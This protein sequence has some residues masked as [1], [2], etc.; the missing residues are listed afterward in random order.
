MDF[1]NQGIASTEGHAINT[2]DSTPHARDFAANQAGSFSFSKPPLTFRDQAN[3][4]IEKGLRIDNIQLAEKRLSDTNYYRLRGF[5]MTLEDK[6]GRFCEGVSFDDIWNT[7]ELD[8]ALRLWLWKTISPIEVKFRT[9]FAYYSAHYIGPFGYLD[10]SNFKSA[11]SHEASMQRYQRECERARQQKVPYVTH[12]ENRYGSLPV[13]AAVELMSFGTLSRLYGNLS[14]DAGKTGDHR[15]IVD[16]VADAFGMR[17]F[18][19]KNWTHHLTTIRNIAGHHD[20]FYNRTIAI[21]PKLLS[22]DAKYESGK[23]FPTLLVIKN[24][25]ELSWPDE[26]P[27][28]GGELTNMIDLYSQVDLRPMGFPENWRDVLNL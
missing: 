10:S 20:R 1:Q 15:G 16:S 22:R 11:K 25:Y 28:I 4:M 27:L 8:R 19:L 13:W 21:K 7:Y 5:W 12:N 23:E 9:Q 17:S 2:D 26:W 18:Y 24:I 3:H 14:L 6:N